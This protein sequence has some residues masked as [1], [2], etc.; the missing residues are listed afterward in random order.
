MGFNTVFLKVILNLN[1]RKK[2]SGQWGDQ[3]MQY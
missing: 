1:Y 2:L 3:R